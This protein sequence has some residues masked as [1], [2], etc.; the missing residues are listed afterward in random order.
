MKLEKLSEEFQSCHLST[1]FH[2]VIGIRFA[3][4]G[5]TSGVSDRLGALQ[6]INIVLIGYLY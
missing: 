6:N 3:I 4:S 5:L 2:V 1:H